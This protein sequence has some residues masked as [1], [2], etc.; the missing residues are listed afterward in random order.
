MP[1]LKNARRE[2][3]AQSVANGKTLAEAYKEA[4]F[5][6]GDK[7]NPSR[8]R[9]RTEVDRRITELLS[10]RASKVIEKVAIEIEYTREKLLGE[11][12]QA[13]QVAQD[14]RNG[15][16]MAMATLGKAKILGLIIDRREVGDVGAFDHMTDEELLE[17]AKKQA[18]ELGLPDP[19]K[20]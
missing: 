16:A 14:A 9:N 20:H 17:H 4:G 18:A 2:I 10:K 12:E 13:R 6:P 3:F 11:L 8:L 15:S 5:I 1:V 19:T 7:G